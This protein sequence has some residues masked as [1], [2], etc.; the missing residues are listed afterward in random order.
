MTKKWDFRAG[1]RR[2]S[3]QEERGQ[4]GENSFGSA[5]GVD[6]SQVD[7]KTLRDRQQGGKQKQASPTPVNSVLSRAGTKKGGPQGARLLSRHCRS[8]FQHW[9]RQ[10]SGDSNQH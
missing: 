3:A 7:L 1:K 10:I 4:R 2:S 5:R 9:R 6:D 8:N